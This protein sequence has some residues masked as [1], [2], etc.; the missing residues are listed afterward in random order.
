M[1]KPLI[2]FLLAATTIFAGCSSDRVP[3][4]HRIDIPQGNVVTQDMLEKL[5][6]GLS[7]RQVQ[8]IMGSP[9]L[10]DVFNQNEWVYLYSFKPGGGERVQRRVSLLFEGERLARVEGDLRQEVEYAV[11]GSASGETRTVAVP[12]H[13]RDED[14]G[15]LR[16]LIDRFSSV[17]P[18]GEPEAKSAEVAS[19][20]G[21]AA[22][23][24][25]S[26]SGGASAATDVRQRFSLGQ[27]DLG[28]PAGAGSEPA[29]P[30]A[31]EPESPAPGA[32]EGAALTQE[33]ADESFFERLRRR[34]GFGEGE[35]E[36]SVDG[37]R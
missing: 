30:P 16:G 5:E 37:R 36:E 15:F 34:L 35:A 17:T 24:A 14:G 10:V 32:E 6:P 31:P 19:D 1:R 26:A 33:P 29:V 3:F 25:A 11:A 13:Y 8:Y 7:R 4:V 12:E 18:W 2:V 21:P 27:E 20:S 23:G 9:M 22:A 28:Q